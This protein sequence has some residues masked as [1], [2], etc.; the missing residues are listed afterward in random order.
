VKWWDEYTA[1]T[2]VVFGHYWRGNRESGDISGGKPD[3]FAGSDTSDWLG[4]KRNVYCVD[5]SVGGRF[6]ERQL[7]A[8]RQ[9]AGSVPFATRLGAVR[10]PERDIV[11][12]D[13]VT[14]PGAK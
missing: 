4:P 12:D 13:G 6:R 9:T 7:R 5:F 3:L 8:Q 10:W 2:P 1:D 14:I 11:F